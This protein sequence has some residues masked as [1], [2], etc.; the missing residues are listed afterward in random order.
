MDSC[1]QENPA[2]PK[3]I[4]RKALCV[5]DGDNGS[6]FEEGGTK[7]LREAST[8]ASDTG[9]DASKS[10]SNNAQCCSKCQEMTGTSAGLHALINGGYKHLNWYQIQRTAALGCAL[11]R[12]IQDLPK[13]W[14][15]NSEGSIT[16]KEVVIRADHYT[17]LPSQDRRRVLGHPLNL[18]SNNIQ[19]RSLEVQIPT[20]DRLGQRWDEAFQDTIEFHLVTRK[21]KLDHKGRKK[22]TEQ[23]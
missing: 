8:H 2:R 14:V 1:K 16:H 17:F 10:P 5:N 9:E 21:G 3:A 4:K 22:F 23:G 13:H 12:K 19:L 6:V 20:D 15:R 7:K 18:L 11:C